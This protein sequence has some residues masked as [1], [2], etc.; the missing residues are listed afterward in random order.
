MT[1]NLYLLQYSN[2]YNRLVKREEGISAYLDYLAYEFTGI[3]F[4]PGDGI[5]TQHV[6][7]TAAADYDYLVVSSPSG[8]IES[9]WFVI[10]AMR[11]LGGQYTLSLHRD[12]IADYYDEIMQAPL[13]V[14][15]AII[16][17]GSPLIFNSEGMQFNQIKT[18]E[19]AIAD[20][21]GSPWIVGYCATN[22]FNTYTDG[23]GNT[24][25][26]GDFAVKP[27][28]P[29]QLV[30]DFNYS[31]LEPLANKFLYANNPLSMTFYLDHN[32]FYGGDHIAYSGNATEIF[33]L[34]NGYE[35]SVDTAFKNRRWTGPTTQSSTHL[36]AEGFKKILGTSNATN[37]RNSAVSLLKAKDNTGTFIDGTVIE[38][39]NKYQNTLLKD[40]QDNVFSFTFRETGERE[41]EAK[42]ISSDGGNFSTYFTSCVRTTLLFDED[43]GN[44]NDYGYGVI[45]RFKQYT[46]EITKNPTSDNIT[47]SLTA[48]HR[49]LVDAPYKMF[50]IPYNSIIV[51]DLRVNGS[52]DQNSYAFRTDPIACRSI[53][54]EIANNLSGSGTL[55]DIQVVPYCPCPEWISPVV[56]PDL[57]GGTGILLP[58]NTN[59]DYYAFINDS[60]K[61]LGPEC[62]IVL[63]ANSESFSITNS[64][65]IEV[66]I[67]AID[68][69]IEHETSMWRLNSPN[70]AG[71]FEF[72]ATSNRGVKGFEINCTYKPYQPY[73]HINPI[74]GGLYGGDFNDARGLV[75]SGDFSFPTTSEAWATFQ[76]QNKSYAEAHNRMI[77]NM[78]ETYDIQRE[79][80]KTAGVLNAISAG[81][82]GA[83]S[84][85]IAGSAFGPIGT[86]VG[87]TIGALAGSITSGVGAAK[88]L[89]YAD[90]LQKEAK[91]Y[92]Q[93]QYDMNL[94]NIQAQPYT[95]GRVGGITI[96]NK[97]FP[98]L[99][100]YTA[101]DTEKQALRDKIKYTGMTINTIGTIEN[102]KQ[103]EPSFIRGQLIR[104]EGLADDYHTITAIAGELHKGIYI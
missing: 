74:F 96:N 50:A 102:Y 90:R 28:A 12:L 63:F 75:C 73:I 51:N 39:L 38:E 80:M 54:A 79:Q 43:G 29:A 40:E 22:A 41:I 21:T 94:R 62:G 85:G 57:G 27:F 104:L 58:D 35:R 98:F 60:G 68:F 61:E 103:E 2:Y 78:E 37:L 76:I 23:D 34:D 25:T 45:G 49:N 100:Y 8:E 14:E 4:N 31:L 101:T 11:N 64:T 42:D 18:R 53:A 89:E 36:K 7:N 1:S 65:E 95:L 24:I 15:R 81:I 32:V 3:N 48:N 44:A 97:L 87:A 6:V 56:A 82:S 30:K 52:G 59:G 83:A 19:I 93:D 91:S 77:E 71:A 88:D 70:Y 20:P 16:N 47:T 17:T 5:D 33:N 46:L 72:K 55:Y 9:R 67:D 69:K 92:A 86:G 66:P 13:Y 10:Q 99:E 84:G 26:P